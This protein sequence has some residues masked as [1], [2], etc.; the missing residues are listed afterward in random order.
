MKNLFLAARPLLI[1][2]LATLVFTVAAAITHSPRTAAALALAV[3]LIQL[4][5]ALATRRHVGALQWV[6]LGLVAVTGAATF[7]TQDAR[8]LMF[9]P[10]VIYLVVGASM[11]ERGW[12]KR[13]LP[14]R[15]QL[16]VPDRMVVASGYVW[17]GLMALTAG[18]NA[19]VAVFAGFR[20][21]ALF[22]GV[23]PAASKAALFLV[24]YAVM[25]VAGGRAARAA[26]QAAAGE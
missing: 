25:R 9:K 5:W 10:S 14:P 15:A 2:L 26:A 13:Y 21:W 4:G 24:Q 6:S 16:H 17:A 23:F 19:L 22:I 8:F 18:L 20:A 1:D 12:M 7:V 11:L 3:G